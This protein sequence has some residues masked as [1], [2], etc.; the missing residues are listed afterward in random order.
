MSFLAEVLGDIDQAHPVLIARLSDLLDWP[1][2]GV[3]MNAA[4]ALGQLR[5]NIP[6]ATIRRLLDLRHDPQSRVVREAADEA[7]AKILSLE[8]GIEDD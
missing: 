1:Y 6:D 8:T 4:Q 2:G 7:L 3:R 5:R